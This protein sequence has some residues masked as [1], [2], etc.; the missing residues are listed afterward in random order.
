LRIAF[1]NVLPDSNKGACA[2]NWAA[3]DL[4]LDAFPEAELA[5]IP[6]AVTPPDPDPFR[7]TL[8]RYPRLTVLPPLF[9]GEGRRP[10]ALVR[11][12]AMKWWRAVRVRADKRHHDPTL[13]WIRTCDLV[14]AVGGVNFQTFGG[15]VRDDARFVIRVLPLL[16]AGRSGR[17][18]VLIGAQVGPFESWLGR[19]LFAR[20]LA[21]AAAVFPRDRTSEAEVRALHPESRSTLLPD[22][23]L[24]LR[25]SRS[26]ARSRFERR[27]LDTNAPTLALVISSALRAE[28]RR[29]THIARFVYIARR[30]VDAGI[31]RQI[32]VVLQT[33]EDREISLELVRA[34]ALDPRCFIDDDLNPDELTNLY[35]A[36]RSVISSRLHAVLLSLLAGVPAISLAAEVTFKERAVLDLLGLEWLWIPMT[37]DPDRAAEACLRIASDDEANRSAV[38]RAVT[39]ARAQWGDVPKRLRE[40]VGG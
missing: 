25:P 37:S 23:A 2:L 32:V 3:L 38:E 12:L 6:T 29:E 27:G 18:T 10:V 8:P 14:I 17:T 24:A 35:G 5:L 19:R 39:A 13:E 20:I 7:H 15:T 11:Q 22:S 34:L 1:V 26:D 30:L 36:C 9:D 28:D 31:V 33:D 4:A 16:A 40:I 21:K